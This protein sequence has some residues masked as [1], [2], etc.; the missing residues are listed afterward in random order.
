[1]KLSPDTLPALRIDANPAIEGRSYPSELFVC[2]DAALA[3][4]GLAERLEGR[5]H[6]DPEFLAELK[7]VRAASRQQL[8]ADLGPYS[9]MVEQLQASTGEPGRLDL[10][11]ANGFR[12]LPGQR[13]AFG[14]QWRLNA[15]VANPL[16]HQGWTLAL[17]HE[18]ARRVSNL[19]VPTQASDIVDA[20]STLL[21]L[22]RPLPPCTMPWR[23]SLI[24][25]CVMPKRSQ[26]ASSVSTCSLETGSLMPS[27]RSVVGTLWSL[28]AR[29]ADRRHSLRPAMSRPS[30]AWGLVTSCSSWRSMYS[31]A[32]PSSSVWTTCS[33]QSLS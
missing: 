33:S 12:K 17:Q 26:L 27:R 31:T 29:L 3:L 15:D 6:S 1:M 28:T 16:S 25:N 21:A 23:L 19:D 11:P 9:A 2:G 22:R 13:S 30:K 20:N 18:D 10:L 32:V 7:A 5:L 24:M 14:G 4:E 8:L